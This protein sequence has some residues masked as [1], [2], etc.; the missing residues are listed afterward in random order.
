MKKVTL[1]VACILM[2][3]CQYLP[4]QGKEQPSGFFLYQHSPA[5]SG[6]YEF[7]GYDRPK[8]HYF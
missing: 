1:L 3:G 2:S 4:V 6:G 8:R 5:E 7:R